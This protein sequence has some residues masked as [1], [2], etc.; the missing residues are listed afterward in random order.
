MKAMSLLTAGLLAASLSGYA[1]ADDR[2]HASASAAAQAAPT[3]PAAAQAAGAPDA[4]PA[5]ATPKKKKKNPAK[6]KAHF[7]PRDK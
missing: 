5:Q 4:A 1:S 2:H 3:A 7:H 6:G